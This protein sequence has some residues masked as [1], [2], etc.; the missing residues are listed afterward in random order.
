MNNRTCAVVVT[1]NRI[2]LLKRCINALRNQTFILDQI[3]VVNNSS[4]DGTEEWLKNQNDLIVI[5]QPNLGGSGGFHT[6]CKYARDNF[7]E[8]VWLMDDDGYP[9]QNAFEE[10]IKNQDILFS[11]T[12]SLVVSEDGFLLSFPIQYKNKYL[13]T[14]KDVSLL[15]ADKILDVIHPFNGTFIPIKVIEKIGLPFGD[16][17]IWGDEREYFF[18]IRSFGIPVITVVNSVFFHPIEKNIERDNWDENIVWRKYYFYRNMY[19]VIKAA[20]AK[21]PFF[22]YSKYI[23]LEICNLVKYQ[24]TNTMYKFRVVLLAYIHAACGKYGLT[25]T[26]SRFL[27]RFVLLD[28]K[29]SN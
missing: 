14:I 17:F 28:K 29:S 4:D 18:R 19:R 26:N 2:E 5:T 23:F 1:Y 10:L 20:N 6:G 24:K 16:M 3:L 21:F 22:R 15:N 27:R 25:P 13:L 11:V 12:N 8:F 7:F 9:K